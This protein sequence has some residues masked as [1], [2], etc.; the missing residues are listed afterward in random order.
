MMRDQTYHSSNHSS[1]EHWA[2]RAVLWL[3]WVGFVGYTLWLAPLD[4][5]ETWEIAR[6]LVTL[7]WQDI[8]AYLLAIFWLMG[9][10]PM[11]YACLMFIDGRT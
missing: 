3:I 6:K 1:K 4:R 2:R 9:V 7:Q 10:W 8:N 5:P 11:I